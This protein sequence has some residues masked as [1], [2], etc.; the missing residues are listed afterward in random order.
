RRKIGMVFQ[1]PDNQFVGATVEDDVA[2]GME[3]QGIPREEMIARVDEA[4]QAVNMQG[5][6][7]KEPAR[8]SGGQK[9]RVAIAGIIALRPE[10]II[11]DEATSMLDPMGCAEIMSIIREIKDKYHLTVLSITHDLE[12]ASHSDRILV[13]KKGKMIQSGSPREIF[14][15]E[16]NMLEFGLDV[17][18]STSLVEE[19]MDKGLKIPEEYYDDEELADLL[20]KMLVK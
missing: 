5:F 8:L 12:E 16:E 7:D 19:L 14:A 1:N 15:R 18:F 10:L 20:V 13:M 11:L 2:F 9:Q 6:K 17:P 3:N 4:L